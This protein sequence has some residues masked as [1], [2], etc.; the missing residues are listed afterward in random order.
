MED[1]HERLFGEPMPPGQLASSYCCGHFVVS[2]DRVI[3]R[4]A[5]F[6]QRLV[7]TRAWGG[8]EPHKFCRAL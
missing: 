4:P 6:Y 1:A 5:S 7:R 3:A 2:R 8:A